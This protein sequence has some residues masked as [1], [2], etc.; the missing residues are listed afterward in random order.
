MDLLSSNQ[1]RYSG[2]NVT[3]S[4]GYEIV[5]TLRAGSVVCTISARMFNGSPRFSYVLHKEY[6]KDGEMRRSH[7]FDK[8]HLEDVMTILDKVDAWIK[9]AEERSR[10]QRHTTK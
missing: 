10:A 2:G 6:D 4:N 5:E 9:A 3:E 8:R 7:W 1:S